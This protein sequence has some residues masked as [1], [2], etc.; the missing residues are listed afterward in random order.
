MNATSQTRAGG[1]A[2]VA[3]NAMCGFT[4]VVH[5]QGGICIGMAGGLP[6]GQLH[7]EC[8]LMG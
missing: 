2:E 6:S 3:S 8:G 5:Y 1:G 4:V 7:I